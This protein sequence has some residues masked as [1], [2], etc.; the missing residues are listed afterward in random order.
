LEDRRGFARL[1]RI[2]NVPGNLPCSIIHSCSRFR[3]DC[4]SIK[5]REGGLTCHRLLVCRYWPLFER[6]RER[7]RERVALTSQTEVLAAAVAISS[8]CSILCSFR[9]KRNSVNR[10]F[11]PID[12]DDR[13]SLQFAPHQPAGGEAP[14][15]RKTGHGLVRRAI[16]VFESS[17]PFPVPRAN[18]LRDCAKSFLALGFALPEYQRMKFC[19]NRRLIRLPRTA[20]SL[21]DR[22]TNVDPRLFPHRESHAFPVQFFPPRPLRKIRAKAESIGN[23]KHG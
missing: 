3:R 16:F 8:L 1:N 9:A 14:S 10:G 4:C 7:E 17:N 18:P 5:Y 13:L 21:R 19:R 15:S 11:M 20:L 23:G 22:E 2:T 12:H 6:E